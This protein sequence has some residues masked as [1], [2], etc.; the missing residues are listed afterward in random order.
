MLFFSK[1]FAINFIFSPNKA[2]VLN[3][4]AT[5]RLHPNGRYKYDDFGKSY[6][7][8]ATRY[9]DWEYNGRCTDF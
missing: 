2:A 3:A 4:S 6:G 9:G 7:V 5:E 8:N 1:V